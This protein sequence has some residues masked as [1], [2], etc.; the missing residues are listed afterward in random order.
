MKNRLTNYFNILFNVKTHNENL[1]DLK[2]IIFNEKT[3]AQSISLFL[4]LK[5]LFE[6]ELDERKTKAI[7]ENN[8]VDG[9]FR[10][11]PKLNYTTVKDN[12]Y[13]ENTK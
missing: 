1:Q 10:P 4:D 3:T 12:A 9:Y 8:N 11:R 2:Y 6:K 5:L 13:N 7:T